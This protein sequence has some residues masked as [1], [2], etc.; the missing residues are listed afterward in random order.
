MTTTTSEE[1]ATISVWYALQTF[2]QKELEVE[3]FLIENGFNP[4]IPRLYRE[5]IGANGQKIRKLMPAIHN[6]LFLPKV[7]DGSEQARL[8][9]SCPV[10]VRALRHRDTG[11][12]YEI[13]DRQMVELRMV[14]DPSYSNTFY[15]TRDFAEARPGKRIRVKQGPFK[16]LEGKLVRH[17][18]H[19]FVVISVAELGVFLR[20]SRWYCEVV[21][22]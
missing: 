14:C 22:D 13:P 4:F 9:A 7:G 19:Y 18:N 6:L 12:L 3:S 15:T 10:P 8:L 2:Y 20:I 16:G 17:Q 11:A 21:E 5:K 1:Q